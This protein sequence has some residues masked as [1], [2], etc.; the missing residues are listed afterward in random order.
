MERALRSR[1]PYR[2]AGFVVDVINFVLSVAI[3][4][5]GVIDILNPDGKAPVF[6][7]ICLLGTALNGLMSFKYFIRKDYKRVIALTIAALFLLG[8]GVFSIL[9][10]VL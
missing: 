10:I 5:L 3:V 1:R 9:T 2:R 4:I 6:P 7:V 8:V